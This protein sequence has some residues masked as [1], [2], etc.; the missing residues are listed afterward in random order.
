VPVVTWV[1]C[2]AH[3]RAPLD[4]GSPMLP[5]ASVLSHDLIVFVD[6]FGINRPGEVLREL[7]RMVSSP[8]PARIVLPTRSPSRRKPSLDSSSN[9]VNAL[10]WRVRQTAPSAQTGDVRVFALTRLIQALNQ[11]LPVGYWLRGSRMCRRRLCSFV[12]A[13]RCSAA[14][15][16]P[17]FGFALWFPI[18]SWEISR[19]SSFQ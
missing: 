7:P 3:L 2:L 14:S 9:F 6:E 18:Q 11:G 15:G 4:G 1:D 16:A 17:C 13:G 8:D 5:Q 19:K 12:S 10:S